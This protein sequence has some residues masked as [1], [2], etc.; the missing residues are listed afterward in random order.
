VLSCI[1]TLAIITLATF[2]TLNILLTR[3]PRTKNFVRF[4]GA[5]LALV[6]GFQWLTF[7]VDAHLYKRSEAQAAD[8]FATRYPGQSHTDVESE[9]SV[10]SGPLMFHGT[11][12]QIFFQSHP[13]QALIV[14]GTI[15]RS[16]LT[17]ALA[18]ANIP[19]PL[20]T[21]LAELIITKSQNGESWP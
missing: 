12:W 6:I 10:T 18:S 1:A 5:V 19:A 14:T 7:P 15:N 11:G 13:T 8:Y 9:W 20:S 16:E 4:T 3:Y 17:E 21:M 2:A